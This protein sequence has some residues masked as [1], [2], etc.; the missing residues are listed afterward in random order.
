MTEDTFHHIKNTCE[1][2]K[3]WCG[4]LLGVEFHFKDIE[5]AA[6]N[7]LMGGELKICSFCVCKVMHYLT[8]WR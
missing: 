5:K 6:I 3:S 2:D 8:L 1:Q 7:G 4:E